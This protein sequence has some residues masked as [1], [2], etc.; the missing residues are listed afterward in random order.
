MPK[1]K[2]PAGVSDAAKK[3]DAGVTIPRLKLG[4]QGVLGLRINNKKIVEE[5]NEA[6][7]YPRFLRTVAELQANPTITAP[8]N[9]Y[10]MMLSRVKWDVA[11][12]E[13]A[14]E[15]DKERAKIIKTMMTD[16]EGSWASFIESVLTYLQYGFQVSEIVLRR[17]LRAN[18]SKYDD[19][20][21]G[22]KKLAPRS[23][24]TICGWVF[25]P[26]GSDLIAV[27][28]TIAYAENQHLFKG[29]VNNEN[30]IEIPREKFLLFSAS[31]TNGNPEGNSILKGI[32]LAFKRMEML[33]DQ[34]LLTAAKDVQG[35]LKITLPPNYLSADASDDQKA[36]VAMF[37]QIVDDYSQGKIKGL[38]FPQAYDP[39]T[40][41]PMFGYELLESKSTPKVDIEDAIK[42]F[43]T[44]ILSALSVDVLRLGADGTG[45]FSLAEAKS[46][47]LALAI[48]YRLK[49]IAEVLN[50]HLMRTIYAQNGWNQENMAQ[51]VY[52]DIEEIDLDTFS[53]AIQRVF[54]TSAIEMDRSVMNKVRE[55]FKV[56]KLPDDMPVDK[57]KLPAAM[58]GNSSRSGDGMEV[59]T[60]GSGTRKNGNSGSGDSSVANK[61]NSP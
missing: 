24:N 7:K 22:I 57:E 6:F 51:F 35:V 37:K 59:G 52:S 45:S 31:A 9:V 26:T 53:S 54:A 48:D 61:E 5:V 32:Y 30:K 14:T 2:A 49:E 50:M 13:D 16:M 43:Q 42:R 44:D 28:Q 58:A 27:E 11:P 34:S 33:I 20:L 8:L 38:I 18:G 47:I 29:R 17:R 23:Q 4:E 60:T 39:E 10:R 19:G 56:P 21:V 36:I 41:Q 3:Q 12:P 25:D 46:S 55:A 40:K 15:I 1:A